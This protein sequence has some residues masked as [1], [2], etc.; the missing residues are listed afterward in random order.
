MITQDELKTYKKVEKHI[1][2][3]INYVGGL[4]C[5]DYINGIYDDYA[6]KIDYNEIYIDN[7]NEFIMI[8]LEYIFLTNKQIKDREKRRVEELAKKDEENEEKRLISNYNAC[9]SLLKERK[10]ELEEKGIA[11]PN[12]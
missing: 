5:I 3:I 10:A 7:Y 12:G 11:I 8:P 6:I 2:K 9:L 1:R 4:S